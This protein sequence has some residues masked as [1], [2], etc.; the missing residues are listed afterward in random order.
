MGLRDVLVEGVSGSG[1]TSVCREPQRRGHH[2]V[3]G[4]TELTLPGDPRT[5][6]PTA[7]HVHGQHV[8]RADAVRALVADRSAP[9]TWAPLPRV[10][11][12]VLRLG[13]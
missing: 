3:D 11:D 8:R 6:A 4:D 7:A 9:A 13:G 1:K 12:E 10:V 5:G 2:A